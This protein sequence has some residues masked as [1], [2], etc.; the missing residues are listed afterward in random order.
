MLSSKDWGGGAE[1]ELFTEA[2]SQLKRRGASV[3]VVGSV[4]ADQ[5]RNVRQRLLGQATDQPRQR[6]FVSTTGES[7]DLEVSGPVRR[8]TYAAQARSAAA[9]SPDSHEAEPSAPSTDES[10]IEATTLADLGIAISSAIETF[11]TESNGL[12]P[13]ELRVGINSLVPLLEEYGA[14]RVFKFVHL[15]NGRTR[16]TDGMI[17]YHLPMDR[18]SDVVSVLEPLF[19][20]RID[21]RE[22]NGEF[23]EQ[24]RI[25][26]GGHRSGWITIDQS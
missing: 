10:P 13:A 9:Q 20:I 26:D 17:H 1:D 21:L 4:R 25:H 19:D 7:H 3:L 16:E 22:Q 18:N 6:I 14:E 23:Q 11:E 8:I 15:T 5:R 2:L 24:W 12:A